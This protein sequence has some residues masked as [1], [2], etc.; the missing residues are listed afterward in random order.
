[1]TYTKESLI[2]ALLDIRA[3]GWIENRRQGNDGGIGNTLEYLL[4]IEE[5]NLPM[6]NAAEWELKCQRSHT[7]SL[8]TL[9]HMEPSPRA[10][11]LVPSMLLPKY[12]W[13]HD[14]AGQRYPETEM[15]FR[16]TI[17]AITRTDRGFRINIDYHEKKITISFEASKV[18][19]RHNEWLAQVKLRIGLSELNPQPYWGFDDLF[20][21]VGAKLHHC[22][23][24]KADVK[25]CGG[26]EYFKYTDM[27]MLQKFSLEKFIQAIENGSVLVDFDARTGHNHG[28]KFILR[29]DCMPFLYETVS[30]L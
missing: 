11:R 21:A 10:M 17:N 2:Q 3:K 25:R 5:N 24:V 15:S 16:Q 9:L 20:H 7:S 29:Q 23:Y 12:G 6:P 4:G 18:N 13:K 30:E 28:T 22:F 1:M 19:S 14:K 8:T 26:V 27:M